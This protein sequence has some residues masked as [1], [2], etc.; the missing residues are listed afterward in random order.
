MKTLAA[1]LLLPLVSSYA[2]AGLTAAE[3]DAVF[4]GAGA[5]AALAESARALVPAA[6]PADKTVN[7]GNIMMDAQQAMAQYAQVPNATQFRDIDAALAMLERTEAGRR[8]CRSFATE[9]SY[10][11]LKNVNVEIRYKTDLPPSALG[12]AV[13]FKYSY[14]TAKMLILTPAVFNRETNT[15]ADMAG[16][17]SHELSHIQDLITIGDS[18]L[19]H[20]FLATEQKAMMT[21]LLVQT[22]LMHNKEEMKNAA[23]KFQLEYWRHKEEGGPFPV[24][25]L[26]KDGRNYFPQELVSLMEPSRNARE[27]L[28]KFSEGFLYKGR[29]FPAP[30][31]FDEMAMQNRLQKNIGAIADEYREW[32]GN[33]GLDQAAYY[34]PPKP[35]AAQPPASQTQTTIIVPAQPTVAP[36]PPAPSVTPPGSG[37]G[38]KPPANN[39][40]APAQP[41]GGGAAQPPSAGNQNG[42]GADGGN[43]GGDDDDGCRP[44]GYCGDMDIGPDSPYYP[45]R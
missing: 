28:L 32:R 35:P 3:L 43:G 5:P 42:G 27:G 15:V 41:N 18:G 1:L 10:R 45:K 2:S 19:Q 40:P 22:Q 13:D 34:D 20:M 33:N 17:I 31:N 7:V 24:T 38:P 16:T 44:N 36:K 11:A 9:C 21:R 8:L 26:N 39:G 29:T 23:L 25:G 14:G 4:S 30:A 37:S 12:Q 6:S